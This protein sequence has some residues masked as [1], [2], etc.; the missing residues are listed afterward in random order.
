[1]NFIQ[2]ITGF[3]DNYTFLIGRILLAS[4]FLY[5]GFGKIIGFAETASFMS[6]LGV[7]L[8]NIALILAILI[9]IGGAALLLVGF[10]VRLAS[11]SLIV[12]VLVASAMFH[13][14]FS[15]PT[16]VIN[17]L[18]NLAITGG[19]LMFFS[20]PS[21]GFTLEGLLSKKRLPQINVIS[22]GGAQ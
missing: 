10:K 12:F 1:M 6:Q 2:K 20:N 14:N 22:Q 7:P 3:V 5:A 11:L 9:E 18:K 4:L 21:Q 13:L 17:L 19:L 16:Q 8:A 15:D